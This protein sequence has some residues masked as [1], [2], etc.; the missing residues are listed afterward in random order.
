M[1]LPFAISV[2]HCSYLIP[3]DIR[4]SIALT[5]R[6]ILEST[7][8]GTREVFAQ[9]PVR[10]TLWSRWGRLVVDLN[11]D[12][13]QR[14]PKGVV[15]EVDYY[16]RN[17]YKEGYR[18]EHAEVETRLRKYYWPYH[19]RLKEAIEAS[20]IKVL[21]DCHSLTGTGPP[22]A[23]DPLKWRKDIVLGNNGGHNGEIKPSQGNT[24]CPPETL[25]MME[26]AFNKSEFSVSMNQPY[27]GG[28]IT[29]HYGHE[30]VIKGKMAVQIEINQDLYVDSVNLRVRMDKLADIAT[31]LHQVFREIDRRL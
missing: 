30:L 23:P 21:F 13:G 29:T 8:L 28:F 1:R 5:E 12:P 24:T 4:Q 11:R 3:Q 9:L 17:I 6:E 10:T 2:P 19:N 16:G 27:S 20:E 18:P 22:E 31:R 14:D 26:E 25:Q 7:D 15:P